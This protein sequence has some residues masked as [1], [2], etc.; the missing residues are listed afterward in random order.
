[1]EEHRS[2]WG[3]PLGSD[4]IGYNGVTA[5]VGASAFQSGIMGFIEF[6]DDSCYIIC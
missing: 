4:Y 5:G 3:V 6:V 1:M 2:Y